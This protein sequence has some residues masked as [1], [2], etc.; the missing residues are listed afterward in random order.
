MS[1]K[2]EKQRLGLWAILLA[3]SLACGI[4]AMAAFFLYDELGARLDHG[5][6]AGGESAAS[7]SCSHPAWSNGVC[8]SCGKVCEHPAWSDGVCRVCG[9]VCT[10]PAWENSACTVCGMVCAHPVWDDG[11]C[12]VCG[13]V[14]KHEW[15]EQGSAKCLRC[16]KQL[17]H[18]YTG[19]I[20]AGCGREPFHT[21]SELPTNYYEEAA[22]RGTVVQDSFPYDFGEVPLRVY[23]PYGYDE[24]GQYNLL[25]LLHGLTGDL[26]DTIDKE[27]PIGRSTLRACQLYDH[28]IED[29]LC[30]PF[31]VASVNTGECNQR[32][33]E[34]LGRQIRDGL[35]PYL[36]EH[37]A[38][39]AESGS[40]EDLRAARM[41]IAIGGTSNGGVF[42]CCSGMMWNFDYA[43][44]YIVLSAGP[45]FIT[46]AA[47][48]VLKAYENQ[49]VYF[50]T[51][52]DGVGS[53][54]ADAQRARPSY[55]QLVDT[56]DELVDG[57]NAFYDEANNDHNW[58]TWFACL[59]NGLQVLFPASGRGV[60]R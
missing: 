26:T 48:P 56:L 14:C 50:G 49:G 17:T 39:Y 19:G 5:N 27:Q 38:T 30:E 8:T 29:G 42:A 41:H 1:E 53:S 24:N 44:N 18:S 9:T 52:Y 34:L 40:P 16:G 22:H 11:V 15:H 10:H 7:E 47:I 55:N 60:V 25:I 21:T 4:L 36:T 3:I 31:I 51:L 59:Y 6:T 43:A 2:Q 20:C 57:R 23:L 35:L 33:Q 58:I 28:M 32:G 37:Y 12:K 46:S 45:I 13:Y 54:E